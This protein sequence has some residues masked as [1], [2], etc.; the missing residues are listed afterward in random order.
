MCGVKYCRKVHS[1]PLSASKSCSKS[2]RHSSFF[3]VPILF[4]N[5]EMFLIINRIQ[6]LNISLYSLKSTLS[7]TPN[8]KI[9]IIFN[10][11][12]ILSWKHYFN[13][14][15][16]LNF[17]FSCIFCI[18]ICIL[19]MKIIQILNISNI[20]WFILSRKSIIV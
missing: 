10:L 12:K 5:R 4:R 18:E 13:W 14:F 7:G 15:L 17:A 3:D 9:E 16:G 1:N 19:S 2:W 11:F 8:L 6:T 20:L